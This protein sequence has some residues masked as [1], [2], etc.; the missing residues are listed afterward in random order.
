MLSAFD[1]LPW[2]MEP[3]ERA[4]LEGLLCEVRPNLSIEIGTAEGASLRL[5][6]KYS[7]HVHSFDLATS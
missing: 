3:G 6:A 1:D 7:G 5:L 4:A 2:Q